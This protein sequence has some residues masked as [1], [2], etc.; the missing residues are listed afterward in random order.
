LVLALAGCG[1]PPQIG[2]DKATFKAV[3]ALYTAVSL[4]DPK[5]VDQCETN[6]KS[7]KDTGKIPEDASSSL[8]SIIAEGRS[9][10]WESAQ[11]RLSKFMEGQRP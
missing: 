7:L 10:K 1:S 2:A 11:E 9:G 6:L 3:D 4:R 5:L 8:D